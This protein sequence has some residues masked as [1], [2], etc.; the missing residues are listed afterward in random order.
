MIDLSDLSA[1]SKA[2]KSGSIMTFKSV[3]F[4]LVVRFP[5]VSVRDNRRRHL[6]AHS[7]MSADFDSS[8]EEFVSDFMPEG[9][10]G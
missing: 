5:A 7:E 8:L 10:G 4:D 2:A 9:V 6:V 1:V 3:P